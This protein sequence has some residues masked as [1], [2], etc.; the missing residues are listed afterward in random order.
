M[1]IDSNN[2]LMS[3]DFVSIMVVYDMHSLCHIHTPHGRKNCEYCVGIH[4]SPHKL[5]FCIYGNSST[6]CD[7]L[8]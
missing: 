5:R 3:D 2:A 4:E 6:K 7:I 8:K 1:R